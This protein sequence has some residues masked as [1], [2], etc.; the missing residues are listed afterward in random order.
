MSLQVNLASRDLAQAYQDVL[1]ARGIDWALFTYE[2]G[3]NDLKVQGTGSGGLEELE[4]EFSDGRM[5]YAF[6]R[7]KDPNSELPKF[8]QINWCGDGVPESRKGLFYSHSNAVS[9]FLRGSH[10]V[11]SARNEADVSPALIMSRVEGASGARYSAHKETARRFEPIAPVGTNY[12]PVGTPD[13]AAMRRGPATRSVPTAAPVAPPPAPKPASPAI[14]SI[15]LAPSSFAG[16]GRSPIVNRVSAPDDDWDAPVSKPPPPPAASRPPVVAASRPVPSAVSVGP[17]APPPSSN[18]PTKPDED[19]L[20]GPVGTAYTPIKLH[21]KR[22]VNPFERQAQQQQQEEE[23]EPH[24][25]VS[26]RAAAFGGSGK[27]LTWSERQALAKRQDEEE[28]ARSRAASFRERVQGTRACA[29]TTLAPRGRLLPPALSNS[30][31]AIQHIHVRLCIL[32]CRLRNILLDAPNI[33]FYLGQRTSCTISSNTLAALLSKVPVVILLGRTQYPEYEPT[34]LC[35]VAGR[36]LAGRNQKLV[37]E[38]RTGTPPGA[39]EE[40]IREDMSLPQ[41]YEHPQMT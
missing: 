14:R 16:F 8:V 27:K 9:N 3:T 13:I 12:V 38:N 19:D 41:R 2:K 35:Q 1:N 37:L 24:V 30:T 28:A 5:Q 18:V 17:P 4:E 31:D 25:S 7:V 23:A 10:V 22:L 26:S 11:I 29:C 6:V 33:L 32:P 34:T 40:A 20:I 15:P 39:F 36:S 21:P